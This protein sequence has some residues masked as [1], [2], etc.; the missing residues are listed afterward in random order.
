[1]L[2]RASVACR[3]GRFQ[4]EAAIQSAYAVR[5]HDIVPDSTAIAQLYDALFALTRSPV[6]ALNRAVV[7]ATLR[8]PHAALSDLASIED[9]ERMIG[10]QPYWAARADLLARAGRHAE[11]FLAYGSAIGLTIDPAS[12][13]FLIA[14][15]GALPSYGIDGGSDAGKLSAPVLS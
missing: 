15:R 2:F 3:I 4:L 6:V 1:M 9:D 12:R 8:G 7:I 10:Y 14:K 13:R 11:A 5:R